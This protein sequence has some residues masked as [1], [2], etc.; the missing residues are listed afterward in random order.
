MTHNPVPWFEIYVQDIERAKRFYESVLQVKLEK[1]NAPI[2]EMW[3]FPMD[4]DHFGA[5][6]SLVRMKGV[7]SGGNSV[8]VYFACEDCAVEAARIVEAGGTIRQDK[9]SIGEHGFIVIATDSEG[10]SFGLHS[11][12]ANRQAGGGA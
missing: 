7:A 10:N 4:I 8:L 5:G 12:P 3:A 9:M 1:L 11:M 6:G 2:G